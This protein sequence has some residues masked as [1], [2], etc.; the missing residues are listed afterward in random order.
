MT[1][2]NEITGDSLITRASSE[3]YRSNW[4]KIFGKKKDKQEQEK[5]LTEL[6][7]LSEELGLYEDR[8]E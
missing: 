5:A 8:D 6:T 7:Q 3:A 4:D 2:K 1:T